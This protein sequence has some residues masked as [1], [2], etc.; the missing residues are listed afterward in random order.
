MANEDAVD[1]SKDV[2]MGEDS[3]GPLQG[4]DMLRGNVVVQAQADTPLLHLLPLCWV[5]SL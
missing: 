5:R 4:R 3:I 2:K 1:L